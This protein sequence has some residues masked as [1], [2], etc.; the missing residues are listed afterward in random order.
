MTNLLLSCESI[1]LGTQLCTATH[2]HVVGHVPQAVPARAV[3]TRAGIRPT[4]L[5]GI[6][7]AHA[8]HNKHHSPSPVCTPCSVSATHECGS[9]AVRVASSRCHANTCMFGDDEHLLA[10]WHREFPRKAF[11]CAGMLRPTATS[12][13]RDSGDVKRSHAACLSN[14]L[15]LY[16]TRSRVPHM[17]CIKLTADINMWWDAHVSSP[18]PSNT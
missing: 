3:Q 11:M 18:K 5:S 10:A 8:L 14:I 7:L 16:V 1:P 13:R 2:V 6:A 4:R 15:K 12:Y 9:G 17:Y